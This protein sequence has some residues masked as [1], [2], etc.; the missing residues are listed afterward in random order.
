MYEIN[1]QK[2]NDMVK[3]APWIFNNEIVLW[4]A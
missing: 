2:K 1:K 3:L 4:V